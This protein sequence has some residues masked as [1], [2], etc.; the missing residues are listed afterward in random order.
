RP[1]ALRGGRVRSRGGARRAAPGR[2]ARPGGERGAPHRGA[3]AARTAGG[4]ARGP[5]G[6]RTLGRAEARAA[7]GPLAVGLLALRIAACHAP[8]VRRLLLELLL[9][10]LAPAALVGALAWP[11]PVAPGRHVVGASWNDAHA[12]AWTLHFVAERLAEGQ[13]P[14]GHTT[15]IEWPR[16][17]A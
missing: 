10:A 6:R 12:I 14:W 8:R 2:G 11:V 5:G 3:R 1:A 16:G 7:D 13:L 4:P 9:A 15:A 17:S